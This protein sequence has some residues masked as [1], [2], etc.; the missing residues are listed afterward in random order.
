MSPEKLREKIGRRQLIL[1]VAVALAVAIP[2]GLEMLMTDTAVSTRPASLN[3]TADMNNSTDMYLGVNADN[4]LKFG[5]LPEGSNATKRL[6]LES[7]STGLVDVETR[8]NISSYLDYDSS[9]VMKGSERFEIVAIAD[10]PGYYAG[11]VEIKI[12]SANNLIGKKWIN[13]KSYFY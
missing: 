3:V 6:V 5:V 1:I 2:I 9:F 11:E 13:V 4:S 7:T 10:E 12:Q 8:G